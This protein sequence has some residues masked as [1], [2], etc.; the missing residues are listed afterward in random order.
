VTALHLL[1]P[2][3]PGAAWAPFAGV[4]PVAELRAGAW[5]IRERWEAACAADATAILGTHVEAFHEGDEPPVRPVGPVDGPAVVGCS[6]FAPA[7][8][9]LVEPETLLSGPVRRLRHGDRTVGWL[10]PDGQRWDGPSESGEAVAVDGIALRGAFDLITALEHFLAGD[11]ADLRAAPSTGVPDG[12]VVLGR[13]DDVVV[14][15]AAVEPGVVFDVRHG[16][17]VLEPGVEVRHGTRLEGP[18]YV[19]A[20]TRVLGGFIRGSAFGPECRVHCEVAASVFLGFANKSHDGFVGHSVVGHWVNLGALTTTSNLKNTYGPV[21]LEVGGVRIETG[22]QNLGTLF[23]DHAKTAIG[24]MLA[25]GTVVSAGAQV[26]GAVTPPK[27]IPPFAWGAAGAERVT[28]HG[29]LE[30]AERV[31]ARRSVT[32]TPE[33]RRSLEQTFARGVRAAATAQADR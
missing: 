8:D 26:F 21:R 30:V 31:M 20:R 5:L 11:C 14:M 32:L 22:R 29:F 27:F 17:V 28:P 33:R 16:A 18:V 4:R 9:R 3:D 23:G 12:S 19:G 1:E 15:G 7:G 2:D 6:W 10:V 13:A 25:T 24:T